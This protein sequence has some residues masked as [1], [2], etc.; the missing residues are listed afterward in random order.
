MSDP[1]YVWRRSVDI[2]DLNRLMQ[3]N[4]GEHLG[5]E[6]TGLGSDWIEATMPVDD[7]TRQPMGLLHGGASVVLAETLGSVAANL[8]L[9]DSS[10]AAVGL[11]INANHIRAVK[12][13]HVVGRTEPLHVGRSTQVWQTHIRDDEGRLVCVSRLTVAIISVM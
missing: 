5:I 4:M 2:A 9:S 1:S 8:T 6:V 13:G 12:G 11:E 3:G 7:R 10:S